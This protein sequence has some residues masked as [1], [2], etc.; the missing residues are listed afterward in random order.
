MVCPAYDTD[1]DVILSN[2]VWLRA[3]SYA[4]RQK[5]RSPDEDDRDNFHRGLFI[6]HVPLGRWK[7]VYG[8]G[9]IK[10]SLKTNQEKEKKVEK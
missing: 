5:N 3:E 10:K 4:L 1:G 8:C 7:I 6:L 2:E 9:G